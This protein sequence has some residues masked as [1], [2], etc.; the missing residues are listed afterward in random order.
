[1]RVNIRMYF[2]KF[3][4][5][6]LFY[7]RA[8]QTDGYLEDDKVIIPSVLRIIIFNIRLSRIIGEK[9]SPIDRL[10]IDRLSSRFH[11]V[12]IGGA[13]RLPSYSDTDIRYNIYNIY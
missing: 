11:R 6:S 8:A 4:R 9:N 1:M 12:K 10:L 3:D 13:I 7:V 2:I 5:F